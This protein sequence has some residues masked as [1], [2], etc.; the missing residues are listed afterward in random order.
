VIVFRAELVALL[1]ALHDGPCQIG[2]AVAPRARRQLPDGALGSGGV[3]G[4]ESK[5]C[6]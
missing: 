5:G 6:G 4:G 1:L 3:I 2:E